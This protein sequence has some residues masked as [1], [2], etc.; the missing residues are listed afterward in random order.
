MSDRVT[1]VVPCYNEAK[2]LDVRA[3]AAYLSD[4]DDETRL[5]FVDDGSTDGTG[6]LLERL[7]SP[8][9]HRASVLSLER[10]SGKAEAVRRGVLAAMEAGATTVGYWDADLATPLDAI[11]QFTTVARNRPDITLVMGARVQLLGRSIDRRPG[12][13]YLGRVFATVVSIVLGIRVYDT[14]C[15]AKMLRVTPETRAAFA[16]PF[17]SRWIFDVELIA[18]LLGRRGGMDATGI[19]ILELPLWSWRDVAGSKLKA[20]DFAVAVPELARIWWFDL[21][22]G[23]QRGRAT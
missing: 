15:G 5:I 14:Q 6:A 20:G 22:P 7:C 3:F 19:G 17:R 12:R 21:G 16:T 4:G 13:H 23:V 2:R 11:S 10:N 9:P 8:A 1:I 18:R